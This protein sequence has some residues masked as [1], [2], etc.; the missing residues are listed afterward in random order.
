RGDVGSVGAGALN[1][2]EH[3]VEMT[4]RGAVDVAVMHVGTRL[5]GGAHDF[6]C[7]V[8]RGVWILLDEL[9]RMGVGGYAALGCQ[10]GDRGVLRGHHTWC[11]TDH[12]A[13]PEGTVTE[14]G[15]Q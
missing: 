7:S 12:K 2:A 14:I 9:A 1:H 11:V 6:L 3:S 10:S 13:D 4:Q 5:A 8:D 15:L